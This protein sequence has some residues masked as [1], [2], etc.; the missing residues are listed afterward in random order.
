[1]IRLIPTLAGAVALAVL[2]GCGGDGDQAQ[3]RGGPGG[4]PPMPVE[5]APVAA[6]GMADEFTVVGNLDAEYEIEVVAE[7]AARVVD[8]PFAE[9]QQVARGGLLARLDD[10]QLRAE[11]QRAEALVEQRRTTFER[12]RTVVAER[13][14][15]PQDLDDAAANLAVAEADRAVVRA[16]LDKTRITAPFAGMVGARHVSPG[17]YLRPGDPITEL[18][19]IDSLRVTFTAPERYL[20]RIDVGSTVQ[21]RTNAFAGLVLTGTIDVIA[22]VLDRASRSVEVVAHIDNPER[23]LRPGMSA[24][25]TVVLDERPDALTVPAESVFFQGQQAFVYTVAAD[26]TVAMAPVSLGTR[27]AALVE[28][29]GGLEQGQTVV[30]AGHQKLFPGARV[31]PAGDGVPPSGK[32]AEGASS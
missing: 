18:A 29:T 9:G 20:D 22:P 27:T 19:Q 17:S 2:I 11:L 21:V 25:I 23:R 6:S 12:V 1:M 4:M 7:I 31:M 30:R 13:A 16:R 15:A 10:A 14:G 26:S 24:E 5:T 32:P 3:G 28:V 8:L